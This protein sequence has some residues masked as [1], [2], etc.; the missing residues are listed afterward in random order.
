MISINYKILLAISLI[1]VII[2]LSVIIW[3]LSGSD[4]H[5]HKSSENKL[6]KNLEAIESELKNLEAIKSELGTL[7][8]L[9][10]EIK[11]LQDLFKN[12]FRLSRAVD[13]ENFGIR[14]FYH[15]KCQKQIRSVA[16][17]ELIKF[18]FIYAEIG[19]SSKM[20][21]CSFT[22][23]LKMLNV[24]LQFIIFFYIKRPITIT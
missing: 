17:S 22:F 14:D 7:Q 18:S 21:P 9:R 19:N 2:W 13:N 24:L 16:P 5:A 15:Y 1:F 11:N 3:I 20:T 4:I 10:D 6:N 12:E 23:T 8:A